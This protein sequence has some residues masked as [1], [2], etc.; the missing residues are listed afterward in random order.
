MAILS[1]KRIV[2]I[3]YFFSS[4]QDGDDLEIDISSSPVQFGVPAIT[5]GLIIENVSLVSQLLRLL[6]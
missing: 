2:K 1:R 4:L 6:E 5:N 3:F